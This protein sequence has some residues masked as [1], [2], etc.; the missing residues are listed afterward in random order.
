ML[1]RRQ[2][3]GTLAAVDLLCGSV[4]LDHKRHPEYTILH[5][6]YM[7]PLIEKKEFMRVC[8]HE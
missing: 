6:T 4:L 5:V 8:V 3:G 2:R 7:D 1:V